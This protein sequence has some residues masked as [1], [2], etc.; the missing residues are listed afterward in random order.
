LKKIIANRL[1]EIVMKRRRKLIA[2]ENGQRVV[3]AEGGDHAASECTQSKK[4]VGFPRRENNN[5][6]MAIKTSQQVANSRQ[7][8]GRAH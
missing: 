8:V 4:R 1:N 5:N 6:N 2:A 7:P 3:C